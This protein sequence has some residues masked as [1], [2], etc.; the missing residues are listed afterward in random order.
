[1]LALE[2]LYLNLRRLNVKIHKDREILFCVTEAAD[3]FT[4]TS[5]RFTVIRALVRLYHIYMDTYS[6]GRVLLFSFFL[7]EGSKQYI[8][9]LPVCLLVFTAGDQPI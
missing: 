3:S 6:V 5:N 7:E 8:L 1:M 9:I 4:L 2:S